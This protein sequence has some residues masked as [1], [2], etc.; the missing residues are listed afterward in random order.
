VRDRKVNRNRKIDNALADILRQRQPAARLQPLSETRL[1]FERRRLMARLNNEEHSLQKFSLPPLFKGSLIG[2]AA[3]SLVVM[4]L[5][6]LLPEKKTEKF[7]QIVLSGTWYVKPGDEL[8]IGATIIVPPANR[9]TLVFKDKTYIWLGSDTELRLSKN[10]P[11][12]INLLKGTLLASVSKRK[13]E[14]EFKV[15]SHGSVV[16]V[17]GTLFSVHS[18]PQ[19]VK[20]NLHRGKVIFSNN[21]QTISMRPGNQIIARVK[22]PI[23]F[24][25]FSHKEALADFSIAGSDGDK[26]NLSAEK[27]AVFDK[28]EAT[29]NSVRKTKTERILKAKTAESSLKLLMVKQLWKKHN[30][31]KIITITGNINSD[32]QLLFYRAKALKK[33][34]RWSD[35]AQL[36]EQ[37]AE[38]GYRKAETSYLSA[39]AYGTARQFA[40]SFKMAL[41][42]IACGGPN[43]DHAWRLKIH[44]LLN[45]HNFRAAMQAANE[46]IM[47]YPA[48]AHLAEAYFV[49]A[50]GL[51]MEKNWQGALNFYKKYLKKSAGKSGI[52]DESQFYYGYC[53]VKAGKINSGKQAIENY[54]ASFPRGK[55]AKQARI[56]LSN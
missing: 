53:M 37:L 9:A 55:H 46:Y 11:N 39:A 40:K 31:H 14:N 19:K 47:L 13:K 29:D 18:T 2:I 38:K 43:A 21:R 27:A 6:L 41:L 25:N 1:E 44:A 42:A 26:F 28:K 56:M 52:R 20:V 10:N 17:V 48:G 8:S 33:L 32:M 50:T 16:R 7:S 15:L 49:K 45:M 51:R 23:I 24:G 34:N 12:T 54:L 22:E 5:F 4:L 36:F 30:Y 3:V 35:A